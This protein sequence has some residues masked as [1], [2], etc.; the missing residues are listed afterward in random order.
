[1]IKTIRHIIC[2]IP[3]TILMGDLSLDESK[4]WNTSISQESFEEKSGN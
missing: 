2:L 1:M 4:D 3:P